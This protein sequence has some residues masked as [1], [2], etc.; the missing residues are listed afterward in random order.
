MRLFTVDTATNAVKLSTAADLAAAALPP[1]VALMYF[2]RVRC[3]DCTAKAADA[4]AKAATAEASKSSS[5]SSKP[6][7]M[8]YRVGPGRTVAE[9]EKHVINRQ[10][11]ALVAARVA[12]EKEAVAAGGR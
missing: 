4:A 12:R 10:H 1:G 7:S 9:F 8:M 5:S 3:T 6:S 11:R 2:P